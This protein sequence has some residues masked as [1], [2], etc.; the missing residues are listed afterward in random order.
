MTP[1]GIKTVIFSIL[2]SITIVTI[3]FI[4]WYREPMIKGQFE[5]LES[6]EIIYRT[7]ILYGE[8]ERIII[9]DAEEMELFYDAIEKTNIEKI[10]HNTEWG[11]EPSEWSIV[12]HFD[13]GEETLS[14][15]VS[16]RFV[17][18]GVRKFFLRGDSQGMILGSNEEL[19]LLIDEAI[20]KYAGRNG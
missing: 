1:K 11:E 5:N 13:D 3:V 7:N 20:G 10:L 18:C 17:E 14:N 4:I 8:E 2:L 6:V 9:T 19:Y 15:G 16:S 12:L